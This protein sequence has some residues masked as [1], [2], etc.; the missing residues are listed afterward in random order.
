MRLLHLLG[1][2]DMVK[3]P[4]TKETFG[5]LA[6]ALLDPQSAAAQERRRETRV[7]VKASVMLML[8]GGPIPSDPMRVRVDDV[9][10]DGVGIYF[11]RALAEGSRFLLYLPSR[12][13]DPFMV[14]CT[15]RCCTSVDPVTFRIG[16]TFD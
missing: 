2:A 12:A 9:S 6:E 15:V 7:P 1:Q 16:A 10:P 14:P 3:V 8:L 11:S 13:T 4:L 5:R